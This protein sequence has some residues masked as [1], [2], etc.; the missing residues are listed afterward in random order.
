[1]AAR[2]LKLG[3]TEGAAEMLREATH[4][5]RLPVHPTLACSAH[6]LAV[7]LVDAA[8]AAVSSVRVTRPSIVY[9]GHLAPVSG[10]YTVADPQVAYLEE[11]TVVGGN[12]GV[13][14]CDGTWFDP[15]LEGFDPAQMRLRERG[16][17]VSVS[18]DLTH[19]VVPVPEAI[20]ASATYSHN[21]FHFLLET[22]PRIRSAE[23][24]APPGVP[25]LADDHMPAQH[26]QILRLLF[27]ERPVQRLVRG[28][29]YRVG[30][31][32]VATPS[33]RIADVVD[34][35]DAPVDAA[36]YHPETLRW[37]NSLGA[38]L[39]SGRTDPGRRG[40]KLFL[41]RASDVRRMVNAAEIEAALSE[42]GFQTLRCDQLSFV[43]QIRAI[44]EADVIVAQS[45]AHLANIVFARPGT[46]VI[47][48]YSD[49]PCTNY[50]LWDGIGCAL[51][52]QVTNVVGWRVG[53]S[54]GPGIATVHE[55]FTLPP[56][57]LLPLV[58][59]HASDRPS[60]RSKP[61]LPADLR[62]CLD[63]LYSA[64]AEADTITAAW[65]VLAEPTP[66]AFEQRLV[67]L[68]D[69]AGA[70]IEMAEAGALAEMLEH[71][72][73]ADFGRN[74]RSGFVTLAGHGP[75]E[76][77]RM[78]RVR[79]IFAAQAWQP[80][81][82]PPPVPAANRP[83][84]KPAPS[85]TKRSVAQDA[86]I[87][88]ALALAMLCFAPRALP[89]L[90]DVASHS[91]TIRDR[92]LGWLTA[93]PFL[94]R[95]GEDAEH[96]AWLARM[97]DW[98][99]AQFPESLPAVL[100]DVDLGQLFL[101]DAPVRPVLE[102]R[103]RLLARVAL[104]PA[105][106]IRA[107]PRATDGRDGRL[108]VGVLCRTFEKGPDSEA[109][110]SI[111]RSFDRDRFEIYA[112]SPGF[113]DRVV[114]DDRAFAAE[115]DAAIDHRRLLRSHAR[116]IRETLLADDLDV[117]LHANATTYGLRAQEI[118]LWHR[119]APVQ[120]ALNSH[121]PLAPGF[122]SFDGYVT[123]RS[124]DPAVEADDADLPERLIRCD[125]PVICYLHSLRARFTPLFERA[126]L[127]LADDDIVLMNAGSLSKLRHDCLRT[128]MRAAAAV[129]GARLILAP[130][131][132][133]WVARSQAFAFNRQ[134]AEMAEETGLPRERLL[135]LGELSVAEAESALAL[136]DI[137]LNPF[138][139][140]GATMTHLALINGKPPVTLRRQD[141]RSI[142]QFLVATAGA[143]DLLVNSPEAYVDCVRRLAANRAA[144]AERSA[145]LRRQAGG[146]DGAPLAFVDNPAY[147]RMMQDV[148]K[149]ALA[150]ARSTGEDA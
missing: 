105:T 94:F 23:R 118:A 45:G 44:R 18:D 32:H 146:V 125:G 73:F 101:V 90:R 87:A 4:S 83:E 133:G 3:D 122:P 130:Y 38:E 113:R 70:L 1:M 149:A 93:P 121:V 20:F 148:I 69:R 51:D 86:L 134:L 82:P 58:E 150:A 72:F 25:I 98:A 67:A 33:N 24:Q 112:Y 36:R 85:A 35:L 30:R 89:L 62:G 8:P 95:A 96:V 99:N 27:P 144:L 14:L 34:L 106:P 116:D 41:Q 13:L 141:T 53:G 43:E 114:R 135:V 100:T 75:D 107:R 64:N 2:L 59:D 147:S 52:L 126:D 76:T 74:I 49:A 84:P 65:S 31:L 115:F 17:V 138:P 55:D 15:A 117:F 79:D 61:A 71:P 140:G 131:N 92:Y 97:L 16:A 127:G 139:H 21:Y 68:R 56:G 91:D 124:D 37:L 5:S 108:R 129:P 10:D 48:L 66:A 142:D 128:M 46:R 26:F 136:A 60:G 120:L 137:Y 29:S 109:V 111:F 81:T 80:E 110:V 78:A 54:A 119:V 40:R 19:V 77:A 42:R 28:L 11:A 63:A 12:D 145:R 47:A 104:L 103:N 102:A 6:P 143:S 132:P 50:Y 123:G 9:G 57:L 88:R 7:T 22:L 39:D